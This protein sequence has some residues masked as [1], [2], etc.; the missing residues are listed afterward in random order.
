MKYDG[1]DYYPFGKYPGYT[2]D[3]ESAQREAAWVRSSRDNIARAAPTPTTPD[4]RQF[5]GAPARDFDDGQAVKQPAK[6]TSKKSRWNRLNRLEKTYV[7]F[8]LT[9][10]LIALFGS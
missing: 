3:Y 7:I 8:G 5:L 6:R 9:V 1:T 10:L 2:A 4:E